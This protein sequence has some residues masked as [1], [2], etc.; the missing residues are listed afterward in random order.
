MTVFYG[1]TCNFR[2]KT[3]IICVHISQVSSYQIK[4]LNRFFN[5]VTKKIKKLGTLVLY[6]LT[7]NSYET[8]ILG[9]REREE[10]CNG[11][12]DGFPLEVFLHVGA[13]DDDLLGRPRRAGRRRRGLP[14]VAGCTDH[15]CPSTSESLPVFAHF[16]FD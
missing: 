13:L 11:N 4:D 5:L 16:R 3:H 15:H 9:R 14:I 10:Y 1:K 12:V 7:Q 2:I 8:I 6:F